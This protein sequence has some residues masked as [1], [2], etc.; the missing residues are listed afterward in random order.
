MPAINF[1]AQIIR[2]GKN[3]VLVVRVP[4]IPGGAYRNEKDGKVTSTVYGT[5]GGY[6]EVTGPDGSACVVNAN[7]ITPK[8]VAKDNKRGIVRVI[9]KDGKPITA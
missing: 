8:T 1:D 2:D 3:H 9:L 4:L 5:S 7:V 6:L